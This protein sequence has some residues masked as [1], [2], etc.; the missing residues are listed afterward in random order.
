MKKI[1]FP[2]LKNYSDNVIPI[3]NSDRLR[4]SIKGMLT[5]FRKYNISIG[6]DN[7]INDQ[8][9]DYGK[10][11]VQIEEH[12]GNLIKE[13]CNKPNP[14]LLKTIFHYIQLWGGIT[15][16]SIYVRKD[17]FDNNFNFE[18]YKTIVEK[19]VDLNKNTLETDLKIIEEQFKHIHFIGVAFGTKHLRFWSIYANQNNIHLPI[20]DSIISKGL[21]LTPNCA[22]KQYYPY[23]KQMQE[24]AE[25]RK[26]SITALE[27]SLYNQFNKR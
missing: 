25:K 23:V 18:N 6:Q 19:I 3:T 22:W 10:A 17:G 14:N 24:E 15:G 20:L 13:Y 4:K 1:N 26:T 5:L 11:L 21:L 7:F 8:T 27:R 16:R 12:I 2:K 9:Q